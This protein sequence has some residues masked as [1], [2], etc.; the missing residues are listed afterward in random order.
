MGFG[1]RRCA[2]V[3]LLLLSQLIERNG[4]VQSVSRR[5]ARA[6]AAKAKA[7]NSETTQDKVKVA[8]KGR[9]PEINCL[10]EKSLDPLLKSGDA[11]LR[12]GGVT[13]AQMCYQAAATYHPSEPKAWLGLAR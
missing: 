13:K 4:F 12:A 9:D 6:A 2:L 11:H 8:A 5:K 3:Y 7:A 10:K 1:L